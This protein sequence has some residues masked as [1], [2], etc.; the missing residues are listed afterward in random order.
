MK[1]IVFHSVKGGVGRTLALY[2]MA[3]SLR[4]AGKKVVMLDWDYSAPG[5]GYKCG[6]ENREGYVEYLKLWDVEER[7]G[8]DERCERQRIDS[9]KAKAYPIHDGSETTD[10]LWLIPAGNDNSPDYWDFI[11]SFRFHRLFYF[12]SDEANGLTEKS[13]PRYWLELNIR[14]FKNDKKLIEK[15]FA[16][17]YLLLDCK[18]STE[19]SSFALLLWADSVVHF[20]PPNTEGIKYLFD[21][22]RAI[23][24][25]AEE[26]R[27]PELTAVVSRVPSNYDKTAQS[28]FM[29]KL[30][31]QLRKERDSVQAA[32]AKDNFILLSEMREAEEDETILKK[33]TDSNDPPLWSLLHEY[34][35]LYARVAPLVEGKAQAQAEHD[36]YETLKM[37]SD[38]RLCYQVFNRLP[39]RGT[40]QNVADNQPNIAF[41]VATFHRLV[42]SLLDFVTENI[43]SEER[44]QRRDQILEKS[45]YFCGQDFSQELNMPLSKNTPLPIVKERLEEWAG[46]DSGVGFGTIALEDLSFNSTEFSGYFSVKGDAFRPR[47]KEA[48]DF[49]DDLRSFF[50]GY[51]R[52]VLQHM[53]VE[54]AEDQSGRSRDA[55]EVEVDCL[56]RA[57]WPEA[58][59]QKYPGLETESDVSLYSFTYAARP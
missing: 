11:S 3:L 38:K 17:D 40:M 37:N 5:L 10:R 51:L 49:S 47:S 55:F 28:E 19:T 9:L 41:R 27:F 32:L 34:I 24:I 44:K 12:G 58:I 52:G 46:F 42:K 6:L 18:T 36:W 2:H 29:G 7:A 45:G 43:F 1:T 35:R 14:A 59:R 56:A 22:V 21:T 4:K 15:A 48:A 39:H 50:V 8:N 33:K 26:H 57:N 23:A 30:N 13:F 54:F 16:A 53:F 25:Y 20:L 31:E